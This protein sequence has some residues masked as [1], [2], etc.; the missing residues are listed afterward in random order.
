MEPGG[1][2]NVKRKK[3]AKAE[4]TN[5]LSKKII[6][7]LVVI[8]AVIFLIIVTIS[9][10]ISLNS[11][12]DLTSNKLVSVAYENAF[13]IQNNIENAYGQAIG[14][15]NSLKNI[16][17]LPPEEQRDAIDNALAGVLS[18]DENFTTVFAYFELNKIADENG[19]PYSVHKKDIAY[20]AVAYPDEKGTGITFEKHEDAFDNFEKE[21][22]M[23]IK[24]SGKP[25]LMEPYIYQLRGNDIMMI[26]IIAPVYDAEGNFFGVAGCDV[27]L[28]DMQTQ[29]YASTG[30]ESTHMVALAED[31]TVLLD[32]YD[33]SKVGKATS[34]AG[35]ED[36]VTESEALKSMEDGP[37]VNSLSIIDNHT[38]NFATNKRG[39]SVIVPLKM[40]GGNYW[41]L[42]MSID[43]SEFNVAIFMDILKLMLAVI[44]FGGLL[45]YIIY[46]IIKKSLAPVETIVNGAS[47]LEEGKLKINVDVDTDDEL[48][49]LA[50]VINHISVT[51][52]NYV[53]DISH[54]LSEMAEN[55][56][57]IAINQQYIGDFI[58][59]QTSIEKIADSLNNT[60]HEIILSADEVAT[61]SIR[62]SSGAQGLS[63]GAAEQAAAV[64]E[65]AASIENLSEDVS[66]NADDA[67]KANETVMEV[68]RRIE[69]SN[70]EMRKLVQAM[71]D[72]RDASAEIENIIKTI[73]DISSQTN[74]LSLNASIEAARA[75]DAGRGFAVVAG[76]IRDLATK[77]AEA[78]NQTALLIG[79]SLQAVRNGTAIVNDTA[80]FLMT[81]VEGAKEIS[82]SVDKISDASQN[83]KRI[84]EELT[85]GVNLIEKVVQTN[86][87]S[88]QES[89]VTSE[90][91]SQQS[92]RLHNLV[93]KFHL[94]DS[95]QESLNKK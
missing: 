39:I 53:N 78:V 68:S 60:L 82:V 7:R 45:L 18:G 56:M 62:V 41:V 65:L 86:N 28:A 73:E 90:E 14:F 95:E 43:K 29:K 38:T 42:Y 74:L 59:I 54:Q 13:L 55:N 22:Y 70:D 75:G 40:S 2:Y 72:I 15:A 44:L 57:D 87:I 10:L 92:K 94:K 61:N 25:Y 3:K 8:V 37:Y 79:N 58:P 63:K 50:R 77:T 84:L 26:S 11:L 34:E 24:S 67:Q 93:N 76:E 31:G 16:S 33:R 46:Y 48:G 20:E 83:Q 47:L 32:T 88:A 80:D 12:T 19:Q 6:S 17:A 23:K 5:S 71:S 66:A 89:V 21:Y 81:V 91:L 85:K 4:I 49:R 1:L 36:I 51:I 52:D 27:A 30:Y 69:Q 64:D 35:Y 9:G